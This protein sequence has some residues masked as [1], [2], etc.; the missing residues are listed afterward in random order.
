MAA[1]SRSDIPG[2]GVTVLL[3]GDLCGRVPPPQHM[4]GMKNE[5][6]IRNTVSL[7]FLDR[8]SLLLDKS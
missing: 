7:S 4:N 6:A 5:W 8:L 1:M 2:S 3:H